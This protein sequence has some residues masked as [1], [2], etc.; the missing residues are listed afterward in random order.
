MKFTLALIALAAVAQAATLV[1][2][3]TADAGSATLLT[4]VKSNAPVLT[5]LSTFK[6]TLF[7]PTNE[8]LAATVKAGFNASDLTALTQVLTYHAA[9]TVFTGKDFT[10]TAFLTTLQGNEV[11]AATNKEN[12]IQISSAFGTP[13]ANVVRS[14]EFDGGVVH[15]VDQTLIPPSNVVVTA[16]AANLTSL[17]DTIVAAGLADTT[18]T[19]DQLKQ[20]LLLHVIPGIVHS[21]DIVKAKTLNGV[22]TSNKDATLNISFDGTNVLATGPGNTAAAKVAVADVLADNVIVHVIDT[23]LLPKLGAAPA[24]ATTLKATSGGVA[25]TAGVVAGIACRS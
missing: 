4:L 8:A 22:A 11:K 24:A 23:V 9:P 19:V 18:L 2:V 7:A 21:T 13:A 25:V 3:L 16:K 12:K 5:A 17:V 6:G 14:L 20:V 10:G 15:V 1:E